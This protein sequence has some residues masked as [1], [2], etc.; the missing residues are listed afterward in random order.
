MEYALKIKKDGKETKV[1]VKD[2][3]STKVKEMN[4][5]E[6]NLKNAERIIPKI[7][8]SKSATNYIVNELSRNGEVDYG[9]LL[10]AYNYFA[11]EDEY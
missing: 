11:L 1:K 6:T 3:L 5:D 8:E 7:A 9:D 10:N 4:L 2:F